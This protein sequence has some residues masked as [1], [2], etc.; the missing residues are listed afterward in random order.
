MEE[1]L[2]IPMLGHAE[3]FSDLFQYLMQLSKSKPIT[4]VLDEFQDFARVNSAIFSQMQR[5]WDLNKAEAQM[6]LVVCGSV[7]SMMTRLFRDHKESLYGRQ[8]A[9]FKIEP[10]MPSTLKQILSEYH[11]DYTAE[12]LL[13]LYTFTGGVAKYVELLMD[14][15]TTTADKMLHRMVAK[16]SYFVFEGKNMLIDEFGRDYGRYFDIMKLISQGHNTRSDIEAML[17][18]ELSGYMTRLESDYGLIVKNRPMFQQS[19]GKNVRYAICDNFLRFWF[20]FVYKYSSIIEANA[21]DRLEGILR[22]DY[23]TYSGRVLELYFRDTLLESQRYTHIGSW[24]DRKGEN[25]IDLIAA[26]D[27]TRHVTFYEVK[28]N[29]DEYSETVLRDKVQY[30]LQSTGKYDR[31][32]LEY[33]GLSMDDM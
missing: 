5:I 31:Y 26:D 6:N 8:T 29:K 23:S 15:G 17:Q 32:H 21:Y 24:W 25:E 3:R 14:E 11:P 1:K 2:G 13:A 10:F 33:V 20:R 30:F 7:Y 4:L 16:D 19:T 28:R 22:R 27:T 9:F 12:D 18:T